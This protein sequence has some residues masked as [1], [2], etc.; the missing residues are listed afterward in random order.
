MVT[1]SEKY[2]RAIDV[3]HTF[4]CRTL[5]EYSDI[6][7]LSD[8]LLLADIFENFRNISLQ[9]YKLDPAQYMTAPALSRD[10]MLRKTW[11][12]LELLTNIV[13]AFLPGSPGWYK[14]VH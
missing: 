10:A 2:S 14:S 13:V 8:V 4:Q 12:I 5:S 1:F 7:L 11:V 6:Y 3:W 9:N